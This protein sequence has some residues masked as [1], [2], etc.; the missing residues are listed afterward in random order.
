MLLLLFN[1]LADV[2]KDSVSTNFDK[3]DHTDQ[4]LNLTS[5]NGLCSAAG[6]MQWHNKKAEIGPIVKTRTIAAH[7]QL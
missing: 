5:A 1:F 6:A 7:S 3:H 4:P 2:P